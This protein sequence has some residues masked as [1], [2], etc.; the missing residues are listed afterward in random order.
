MSSLFINYINQIK[1]SL[2]IAKS[3]NNATGEGKQE[4]KRG[5]MF[6][7]KDVIPIEDRRSLTSSTNL[8]P[9]PPHPQLTS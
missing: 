5:E 4:W 8:P 1:P 7:I 9:F 6:V 2:E 3:S